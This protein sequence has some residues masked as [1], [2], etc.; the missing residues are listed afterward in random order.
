MKEKTVPSIFTKSQWEI[1]KL[2]LR[3]T[4]CE[5]CHNQVTPHYVIIINF[6]D[7]TAKMKR[8]EVLNP[9][10]VYDARVHKS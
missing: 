4:T 6:T 2:C 1:F 10:R 7:F 8:T 5:P 3:N 9:Q